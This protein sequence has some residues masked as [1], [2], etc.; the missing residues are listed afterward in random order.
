MS[1]FQKWTSQHRTIRASRDW[2][3]LLDHGLEKPASYIIR[4]NNG[5]IE[6]INGSTGKIDF[7]GTNAATVLQQVINTLSGG[8]LIY[9]KEGMYRGMSKITINEICSIVG[10][11]LASYS[12]TEK[13]AGLEF[14][15][16]GIEI[17]AE[18][19]TL[20]DLYISRKDFVKTDTGIKI[21]NN[22]EKLENVFIRGFESNLLFEGQ[23]GK[24]AI[25]SL[26][27]R[28]AVY[29]IRF[30]G[31]HN[32]ELDFYSPRII[33]NEYGVYS[34]AEQNGSDINFF[35][36]SIEKTSKSA[37]KF[38]KNANV[39]FRGMHLEQIGNGTYYVFDLDEVDSIT[40]ED[41]YFAANIAKAIKLSA[42]S[43]FVKI[44]RNW[45]ADTIATVLTTN[46]A[47]NLVVK[48]N[49][50][51]ATENCGTA[52]I[53]ANTKSHQVSF[54]MAG[55]PTVVKVTP[56]FD[57]SGRWWISNLTSPG[58]GSGAF[59]FNRTYSG[60]YSGIIH[61]NAEYLP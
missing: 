29:G 49:Y 7:S 9:I 20:K 41:N 60:L 39:R 48:N 33:D 52:S 17:T 44:I 40:I 47:T 12:F 38:L 28:S 2:N 15:G 51:F 22:H 56:E 21:A 59:N 30:K 54:E 18:G 31:T 23:T 57:V 36:G 24:C 6:A 8:E 25:Y 10:P 55:T 45:F 61:W 27:T 1:E 14:D 37:V 46:G 16:D 50:G 11:P 32:S 5:T 42:N 58:S 35:G 4:N 43:N 53:P 19:V 34:D 26:A 3:A 13:F